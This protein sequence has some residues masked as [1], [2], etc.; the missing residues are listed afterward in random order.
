MALL[1]IPFFSV[2]VFQDPR[3]KPKALLKLLDAAERAK[4]QLSPV[5][6]SDA[7]INI[8]CLWEDV[9]HA[10]LL[11][12]VGFVLVLIIAQAG[13]INNDGMDTFWRFSTHFFFSPIKNA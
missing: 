11:V 9:S 1:F 10:L 6:V 8:E 4:K 7:P 2:F 13:S 3:T 12:F 5:G